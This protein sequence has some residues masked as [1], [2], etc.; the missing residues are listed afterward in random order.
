MVHFGRKLLLIG[1]FHLMKIL[2]THICGTLFKG[3]IL[4]PETA[5]SI[6]RKFRVE[7]WK[8]F[9]LYPFFCVNWVWFVATMISGHQVGH[10]VHAYTYPFACLMMTNSQKNEFLRFFLLSVIKKKGETHTF[11]ANRDDDAWLIEII[12]FC[13]RQLLGGCVTFLPW[14][15]Q[16]LR[17]R[18]KA[19]WCACTFMCGDA[20]LVVRCRFLSISGSNEPWLQLIDVMNFLLS[21]YVSFGLSSGVVADED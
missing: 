14:H 12:F 15:T 7:K 21:L 20:V 10:L 19:W 17:W 4:I 2:D 6:G 8:C 13:Q 1:A 16:A 3:T 5:T 18:L 11:I 9:N